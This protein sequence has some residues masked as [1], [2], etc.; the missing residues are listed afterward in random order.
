MVNPTQ[1]VQ[2]KEYSFDVFWIKQPKNTIHPLMSSA[3]ANIQSNHGGAW[4]EV[5]KNRNSGTGV[6]FLLFKEVVFLSFR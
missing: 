2:C 1:C 4:P 6:F 3:W 5:F